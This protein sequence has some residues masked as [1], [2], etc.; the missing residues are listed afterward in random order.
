MP[1][2]LIMKKRLTVIRPVKV[3]LILTIAISGLTNCTERWE[4]MN[5][6]PNRLTDLPDEYLFTSAVR[7]AFN[8]ARGDIQVNFGGQYAHVYISNNWVRE[9]DKYN[10]FGTQDYPEMVF[11][12]VYNSS[13]RNAVE[14]L[15]LT[16]EGEKYEN[17]WHHVQAQ[18]IAIISFSRLTDM[19]GDVPYFEAG[20]AKYGIEEPEYDTQEDIYADM[21]ERLKNCIDI[22]EEPGADAHIYASDIDPVYKGDIDK[23][24]RFA[25]SYRLHLAMRAR[26]SDPAKYEPII[27]ES[28]SLPLIESND[29]NPTLETS[30]SKSDLYNPWYWTWQSSQEGVYNLVW[31]E[32]FINALKETSDPRLSFFAT[33]NPDGVYKGMPNGLTDEAFSAWNKKNASI[34]TGEFFAKDQPIYLITAA[35]IWLL[36]AEAA[37]FNLSGAGGD[38]NMGYQTAIGLAM[39]Q[40]N[41]DVDSIDTYL[42]EEE[43]AT[44]NGDPENMF[45]QISTQM[46]IASVPN[47]FESWCTIRR[48]GYPVISQRT[49]PVLSQG[50]TNGYM[51]TRVS[52]PVTKERTING[53]HIDEAIDRLSGSEDRID[54]KVWWDARDI[55]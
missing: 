23:W 41:I 5:T 50:I 12:G 49:S 24:I 47:A 30:E 21:V 14:V 19:F 25:N 28:L 11:S 13:I 48:T 45:R 46:W 3:I 4:E 1:I 20:M 27:A 10:G 9:I 37:L 18:I 53:D 7:G 8:D 6:D 34:P 2:I 31:T 29:Q 54:T 55:H 32:K 22:L 16:S 38:A 42:T 33:K 17:R 39:E 44:L 15:K 51:P 35:Q 36:R 40:W 43:E 26:F 52:Y